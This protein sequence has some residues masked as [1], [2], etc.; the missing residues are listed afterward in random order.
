MVSGTL[1]SIYSFS[2]SGHFAVVQ[3]LLRKSAK[4][5]AGSMVKLLIRL[6]T[7]LLRLSVALQMT[8]VKVY[9]GLKAIPVF[10]VT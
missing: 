8:V 7:K 5:T 10:K 4:V 2:Q 9:L 3:I 6:P 1:V